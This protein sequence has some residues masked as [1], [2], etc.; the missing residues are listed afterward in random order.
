MSHRFSAPSVF[1]VTSLAMLAA[2]AFV[3]GCGDAGDEG[4]AEEVGQVEQRIA[5]G[6]TDT[7]DT[8]VVGIIDLTNGGGLCS[9]S[10]IAPNM[11]LTARHCVSPTLN[12]PNGVVCYQT[13]FGAPHSAGNFWVTTKGYFT[14]NQ[15]DYHDVRE[16]V[17]ISGVDNKFCGNDQAILILN[18]NIDPSEATPLV[19]R[20]DTPLAP[21]DE[22]YAVGY[23]QTSDT[24]YNSAGTRRRR[25]GLFI[26]CVAD[27]CPA[28]YTR[29][30]EWI[31][32]TGICSGDSGGPALDLENR[33]IGVTS[34][35]PAPCEDPVY[36]YVFGWGQWVKDT[37]VYAASLG[38][39]P[40]PA[41]ATGFPTDPQFSM[42]FGQA[43]TQASDC[44]SGRCIDDGKGTYCTRLC[45]DAAPCGD[46]YECKDPGDGTTLCM[47]VHE[48]TPP[49]KKRP[50][51]T[52]VTETCA[53]GPSADPTKPIP[54][55][56]GAAAA[57]ALAAL[58]RRRRSRGDRR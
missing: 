42:P 7:T 28:A 51:T 27:G 35:G 54:W 58:R 25:D 46:G 19:P 55:F 43:C 8:A 13:T 44:V 16:I 1:R 45:N 23:G 26:D 39:Y 5:G 40:P 22:Y 34:R 21:G 33:V 11:V 32:D 52:T 50:V 20:V 29:V 3:A 49:K 12:D 31:G 37:A 56:T 36:G 41:W 48:T 2:L 17:L 24:N 9:G 30:T 4:V 57:V 38:G 15:S 10:L 14:Q 53:M 47:Q 6:Y 18:E